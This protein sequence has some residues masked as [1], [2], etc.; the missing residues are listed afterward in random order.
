MYL[1]V[2]QSF[3][4][5]VSFLVR[6]SGD[7]LAMART[8]ESAIRE[9]DA[10]LPIF[11]VRALEDSIGAAYFTQRIGG[12]LL[13]FFAA[14]ALLM[15]AVGLYGVLSYTVAQRSREMGIRLA[16]GAG[17]GTVLRLILKDGL[18]VALLGL[19]VGLALAIPLSRL[20]RTLLFGVSPT[21]VAS[22][23]IAS[24]LLLIVALIASFIPALRATRIDPIRAIRYE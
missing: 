15:A 21:D 13:G 8:V 17:R 24:T 12:W 22:F 19:A 16:L 10:Q 4:S 5:E 3:A 6:T 7:P 23:T 20:V 1:P 9:S 18:R 2:L 11:D 14:L